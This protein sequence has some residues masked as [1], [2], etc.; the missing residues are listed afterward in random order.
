[1]FARAR[2]TLVKSGVMRWI[3]QDGAE[4]VFSASEGAQ[5]YLGNDQM[6]TRGHQSN[7]ISASPCVLVFVQVKSSHLGCHS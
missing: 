7:C 4:H 5:L 6:A 2:L 1:M 3:T